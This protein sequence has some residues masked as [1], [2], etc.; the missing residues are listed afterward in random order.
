MQR[1]RRAEDRG[2]FDHGWLKTW[3]SFSFAD[4]QDEQHMG[5]DTLRVINQDIVQPGRGF[6]THGHRDMEIITYVIRGA[7][8]HKDSMGNKEVVPAGDVQRMTAGTGVRHS[9]FNPSSEEDLELLQVWIL[10]ERNGLEPGYEQRSF[11]AEGEG[12]KL[13]ASPDGRDSSLKVHQDVEMHAA[14]LK[15][16]E[17]V[18]HAIGSGRSAWVQVVHGELQAEGGETL[19][20]G[21]GLAVADQ[22]ELEL[23]A[24]TDAELIL[25]DLAPGPLGRGA[26]MP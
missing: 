12:L 26:S 18:R 19:R 24:L 3:H 17:T 25:F 21:D 5:F 4:Y 22:P 16:G 1:V 15:N 2:H 9:E 6:S 20:A 14:R 23:Q 8:E 7:V 11:A 10:P 13:L